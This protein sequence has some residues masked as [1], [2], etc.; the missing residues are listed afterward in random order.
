MTTYFFC[1]YFDKNYCVKGLALYYSI[2]RHVESFQ[3]YILCMDD[4]TYEILLCLHLPSVE[5]IRLQDLE[6]R[7]PGLFA[8][9][10]TRSLIEYYFTSTPAFILDV[11]KEHSE[12]DILSYIDA[13]MFLFAPIT[14]IYDEMGE[15]SI[16]IIEH[17]F[18]V[19]MRHNEVYGRFNVGYL[20]FRQDK[21]GMECLELWRQNCIEWCYDRLEGEKFADQKYLDSWP[22]LFSNLTI[23]KHIGV[24]VAPWN[25][26]NYSFHEDEVGEYY[27]DGFPLILYHFHGLEE[28][29]QYL[30]YIIYDMNFE[31]YIPKGNIRQIRGSGIL[32]E[33]YVNYLSYY[34]TCNRIICNIH[35]DKILHS[36]I[37]QGS[38][39]WKINKKA[40]VRTIQFFIN[41][42]IKGIYYCRKL[43]YQDI[44]IYGKQNNQKILLKVKSSCK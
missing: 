36:D 22:S 28:M 41:I 17:R 43:F 15:N 34:I 44:I 10:E 42:F 39:R 29:F 20:A 2:Q 38:I 30:S 13:D 32:K 31:K 35:C 4:E 16:L 6:S 7:D 18:P 9:R 26:Y 25:A 11:L 24:N 12:I 3:L 37:K 40:E 14:P 23:L 1:T 8:T 21:E 19:Q 5:L 33:I 27:V